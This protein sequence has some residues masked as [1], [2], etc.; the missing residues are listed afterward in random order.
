MK[1]RIKLYNFLI[2]LS[3][4]LALIGGMAFPDLMNKISFLGTAYINLLKF[5]IIPIIFPTIML[6]AYNSKNTAGKLLIKTVLIFV[7]M[8][9]LTYLMT[10]VLVLFL[11]PGVGFNMLEIEWAG[12]VTQLD[13]GSVISNLIPNN[14]IAIFQNNSLFMAII[15]A[16]AVGV[17][18]TKVTGGKVVAEFMTGIKNINYKLLEYIMYLTPIGIISLLGG[19]IANYRG[20]IIEAGIKYIGMAYLC[21]LITLIVVMIVP[22][23]IFGKISP[24]KY[25]KKI[26]KVFLMTMSTCSSAATLPVT[27]SVCKEDLHISSETTDIVVPLGT[28]IHMC[29][30]AVSFALLGLFCS[31][32]FGIDV[33]IS[34]YLL[35]LISAILINMAAPGIPNGGVVIGATYLSLFNIPLSFIGFY[36]GIYKLLDMVYTTLNVTGDITANVIIDK[37]K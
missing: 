31:Q 13:S 21:S 22:A 18:A 24:F 29:G 2:I 19:M 7:I 14:I 17:S 15:L 8:F 25:L 34:S 16:Y 36:A 20:A 9:T 5:M 28:T 32:L 11:K 6:V 1:K 23:C 35:M 4:L 3:L 10:S 30:G 37:I 33:T 12:S 27:M 26:S